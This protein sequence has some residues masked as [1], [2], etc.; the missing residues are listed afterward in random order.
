MITNAGAN[1]DWQKTT[2]AMAS[3]QTFG[4]RLLASGLSASTNYF[5]AII[6]WEIEFN[7]G[8]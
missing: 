2:V 1:R 8:A 4:L 3:D 7:T 6:E 5:T